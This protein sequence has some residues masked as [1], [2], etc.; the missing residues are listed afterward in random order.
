VAVGGQFDGEA[1][2]HIEGDLH[3]EE[4][5]GAVGEKL[6]DNDRRRDESAAGDQD[7]LVGSARVRDWECVESFRELI[8]DRR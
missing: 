3:A 4:C 1:P 2:G 8:H 6:A 5:D 7:S